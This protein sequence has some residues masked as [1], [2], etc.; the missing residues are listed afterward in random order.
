MSIYQLTEETAYIASLIKADVAKGRTLQRA[1]VDAR[2]VL[3]LSNYKR[4]LSSCIAI[5]S[6]AVH[7]AG[8]EVSNVKW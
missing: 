7:F 2:D 3:T 5:L 1:V 8:F 4:T 6:A